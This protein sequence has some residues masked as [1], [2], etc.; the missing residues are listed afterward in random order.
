MLRV[1]VAGPYNSGNV[2]GVLANIRRGIKLSLEALNEGF[3]VYCPWLDFQWG[4]IDNISLQAYREN[5]IAWL[6]ASHAVLLVPGWEESEGV[7]RELRVASA[8]GIPVFKSVSDLLRWRERIK[9]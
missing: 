1:Y 2:L 9:R 3:A 6:Q 8:L 5:A 7:K 4:I